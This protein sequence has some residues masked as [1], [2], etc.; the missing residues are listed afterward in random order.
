[1]WEKAGKPDGADF[2]NDARSVLRE[3]LQSGTAVQVNVMTKHQHM[4][5]LITKMQDL[6][7]IAICGIVS[8]GDRWLP[9]LLIPE[10]KQRS[11]GT[12]HQK[13]HQ[14]VH[15]M[16]LI[17]C[18]ELRLD[19][20][21]LLVQLCIAFKASMYDVPPTGP[22][23]LLATSRG[24]CFALGCSWPPTLPSH[25]QACFPSWFWQP[26]HLFPQGIPL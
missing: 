13:D 26:N 21:P 5:N 1:M 8:L 16:Y 18:T 23:M 4:I 3:Q 7:L 6:L 14:P 22:V 17:Q 25:T 12:R 15:P 9:Y 11:V 24:G 2:S 20:A 10:V 19:P